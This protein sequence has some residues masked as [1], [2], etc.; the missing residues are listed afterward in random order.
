MASLS[1]EKKAQLKKLQSALK[2]VTEQ[3]Q[4]VEK[5]IVKITNVINQNKEVLDLPLTSKKN[6]SRVKEAKSTIS[7]LTEKL[8][9]LKEKVQQLHEQIIALRSSIEKLQSKSSSPTDIAQGP[10]QNPDKLKNAV[11]VNTARENVTQ[12]TNAVKSQS[13]IL[14]RENGLLAHYREQ[15][16]KNEKTVREYPPD[17]DEYEFAVDNV[18]VANQAIE[19]QQQTI[20]QAENK[21]DKL[22]SALAKQKQIIKDL[23]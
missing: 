5:N 1:S 18:K 10:E 20:I 9:S 6:R 4:G 12:L 23:S 17:S 13:G 2:K 11:K 3:Y 7:T 16:A 22:K 21:L 8:D 15:L 19:G 14:Q